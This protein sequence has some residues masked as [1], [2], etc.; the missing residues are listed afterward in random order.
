MINYTFSSLLYHKF[1]V[2]TVICYHKIYFINKV[3]S[4][5]NDNIK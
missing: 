2:V 4:T 1:L 3:I 5:V